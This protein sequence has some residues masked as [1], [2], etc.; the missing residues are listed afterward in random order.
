MI[1]AENSGT[2]IWGMDWEIGRGWSTGI[3]LQLGRRNKF[4]CCIG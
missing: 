4:W 1:E 3:K 2:G